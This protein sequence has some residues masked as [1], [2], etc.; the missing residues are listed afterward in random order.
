M[1]VVFPGSRNS[2]V[3][4]SFQICLCFVPITTSSGDSCAN[5]VSPTLIGNPMSVCCAALTSIVAAV[6]AVSL[7]M[8]YISYSGRLNLTSPRVLI[9]T[10]SCNCTAFMV[11]ISLKSIRLSN[12]GESC[13]SCGSR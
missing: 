4:R 7:V 3:G 5:A 11:P 2:R 13:N 10:P 9:Q 8:P 1:A 6:S 12:L